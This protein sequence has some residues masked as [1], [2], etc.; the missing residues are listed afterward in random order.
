M[1]FQQDLT[2]YRELSKMD[3]HDDYVSITQVLNGCVLHTSH[4]DRKDIL[5]ILD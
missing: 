5:S 4:K 3:D 1:P 2:T